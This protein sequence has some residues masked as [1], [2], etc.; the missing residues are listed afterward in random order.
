MIDFF[1]QFTLLIWHLLQLLAI[2]EFHPSGLPKGW[3]KELVFRKTKE[4]LIRRDPVNN[5]V[6]EFSSFDKSAQIDF[7]IIVCLMMQY[8]TDSAS[9]YTFRTLKSALCFVET[10]KISKR[11]FIQRISV[12]DL[13]TF[14]NP[15]DLVIFLLRFC[16]LYKIFTAS[17]P[18]ITCIL[19]IIM[20]PSIYLLFQLSNGSIFVL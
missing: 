10:G 8:Y 13:Y 11:T 4:G 5:M 19:H 6:H 15:A 9:S 20:V 7:K 17:S 1:F 18:V 12:H 16:Y 2:V 14:D 3:V